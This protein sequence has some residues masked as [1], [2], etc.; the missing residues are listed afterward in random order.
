MNMILEQAVFSIT[1]GTEPEFEAAVGQAKEVISQSSGFRSLKLQRGV[2]QPSTY[3]ALI[4]W[5]T[6]SASVSL[7][8]MSAGES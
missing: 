2:E 1:P 8:C 5:D 4:E 7:S 3:L 6:W